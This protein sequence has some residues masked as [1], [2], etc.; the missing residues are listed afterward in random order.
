MIQYEHHKELKSSGAAEL[1][2]TASDYLHGHA[3]C[4]PEA[5]LW[6]EDDEVICA[7]ESDGNIV[8]AM[9]FFDSP[10]TMEI[11]IAI[12]YV[13][14]TRRMEGIH[15]GMY[16]KLKEI[17]KDRG[18]KYTCAVVHVD[19]KGMHEHLLKQGRKKVAVVYQDEI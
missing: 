5:E 12:S 15:T 3:L 6:R 13:I 9:T 10:S 18:R 8:G 19:N 11:F 14:P 2:K 17:V 7:K 16:A 1:I 4:N